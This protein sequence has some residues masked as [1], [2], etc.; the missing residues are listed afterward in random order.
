MHTQDQNV[1]T[2]G[3]NFIALEA[4]QRMHITHQV[5]SEESMSLDVSFLEKE[6]N[7]RS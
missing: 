2:A 1:Q 3:Q 4:V 5:L 7:V 6:L